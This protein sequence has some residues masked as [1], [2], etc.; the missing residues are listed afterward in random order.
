[1]NNVSKKTLGNEMIHSELKAI[2]NSEIHQVILS[3][4]VQSQDNQFEKIKISSL[5]EKFFVESFS[6][7]QVFH[8]HLSKRE[9]DQFL[10]KNIGIHF[11]SSSIKTNK[12]EWIFLTNKKGLTRIMKKK[13]QEVACTLENNH[14]RTKNYLLPEGNAIPFF[15]ELGVMNKEG[16]VLAK[17]SDKFRQ[18]NRFLEYL[19]DI[20]PQILL[21]NQKNELNIIDFGCGKSYLTFAVYHF[22]TAIKNLSV[23]IIGLDLKKDV[24]ENCNQLAKKCNYKNLHFIHQDINDFEIDCSCDLMICLHACNTATDFALAKAIKNNIFAILAVP[25]CQ[26][27]INQ[28]LNK[29]SVS[30][31]LQGFIKHGII[32]ERF[33]SLATDILR[34]ELLET[35]GYAVQIMEFI[36]MSHTP[37]NLLIRAIKTRTK[38]HSNEEKNHLLNYTDA[39]NNICQK[40]GVKPMLENLLS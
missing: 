31:D 21:N 22:L 28:Q 38:L 13:V 37:K 39:Y 8:Q 27:E 7:T 3:K 18:I 40:L 17:Q 25:C 11:K 6:K 9:L 24:I 15:V 16:K 32:K 26:S 12:T 4:P 30:A 36:D 29:K 35:F 20:L 10:E 2:C 23:K 5:K 33:A 14:N 34:S 19:N 1:M